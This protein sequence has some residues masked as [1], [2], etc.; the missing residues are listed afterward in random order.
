[1]PGRT[2]APFYV[3]SLRPR[4]QHA[5]LR[6]AVARHGGRLLA[7]SPLRI[8]TLA[9]P[10]LADALAAPV[11]VFTSPNAVDAVPVDAWARLAPTSKV[12]ATGAGT[13]RAL[14]RRRIRAE[15]PRRM[16]SEGVLALAELQSVD[17]IAIG[18]VTGAGGR[19]LIE[20]ALRDRGARV[21]RA[22]VYAR[23]II[24]LAR[25]SRTRLPALE[26]TTVLAVSSAEALDAL[27]AGLDGTAHAHLQ[28][29]PVVVA[30]DRLAAHARARGFTRVSK[31]A[32]ARPGELAIACAIAAGR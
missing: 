18:L 28:R 26:D 30:S 17:A 7:M 29:L 22:D 13:A 6:R 19:G 20:T 12:L 31:A 9:A 11:V 25:H 4:G 14:A 23:E 21:H 2:P 32:S 15:A 16:D 10:Q 1:M 27:L 3:I 24:P 8:R 5:S